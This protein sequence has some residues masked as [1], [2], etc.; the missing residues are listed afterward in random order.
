MMPEIFEYLFDTYRDVSP[1]ELHMLTTQVEALNF[2]PNEP[3][4]TIFTEIDE[5]A[6]ISELAW[7]PMTEHQK[8][9]WDISTLKKHRFTTLRYKQMESIGNSKTNLGNFK[10]H[11]RNAQKPLCWTGALTIQ[12]DKNLI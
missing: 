6:T 9:T 1:Q 5:L 11:L 12:D 3:V 10:N 8:L 2:P 7:A 4:D